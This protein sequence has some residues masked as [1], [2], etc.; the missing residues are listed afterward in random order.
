MSCRTL[1]RWGRF[2]V[3]VDAAAIAALE[4]ARARAIV[5]GD[6]ATLEAMT[7]GDYVHVETSGAL[8]DK[9]GFLGVLTSGAG[10]F[11]RYELIDNHIAV[12]GEAAIVTGVFENAFQAADG[13]LTSKRARHL[14]VYAKRDGGW[15]NVRIFSS[16]CSAG[17]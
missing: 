9:A 12:L 6:V 14:R 17:S 16:L 3:S 2:I 10:R 4:A 15:L 5:A 1:R 11:V 8:R 13:T 7:A